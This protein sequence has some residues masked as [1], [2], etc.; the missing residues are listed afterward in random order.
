[1]YSSRK[2]MVSGAWS[3][4]SAESDIFDIGKSDFAFE[5]ARI[6]W[7]KREIYIIKTGGVEY[8]NWRKNYFVYWRAWTLW[9]AVDQLK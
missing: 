8:W 5:I 9:M 7:K 2:K 3:E 1:M 6:A 4:I